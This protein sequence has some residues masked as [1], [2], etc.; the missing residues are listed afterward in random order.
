M[1]QS[2][3]RTQDLTTIILH[4]H[5]LHI[6]C[7]WHCVHFI[8]H[9]LLLSIYNIKQSSFGTNL[10]HK[11][12]MVSFYTMLHNFKNI[13]IRYSPAYQATIIVNSLDH[14][15]KHSTVENTMDLENDTADK[16]K[17]KEP[18]CTVEYY[19]PLSDLQIRMQQIKH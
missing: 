4:L 15:V 18:L 1:Y 10:K 13:K 5:R 8:L 14:K 3:N 2:R 7:N 12:Q 16:L 17:T 19:L 11:G 6:L 9:V